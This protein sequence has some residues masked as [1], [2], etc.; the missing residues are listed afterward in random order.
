MSRQRI[1]VPG[2]WASKKIKRLY[3]EY[4]ADAVLFY[5]GLNSH[6]DDEGRGYNDLD[7]FELK[8]PF[9]A[10]K[11][12]NELVTNWLQT[13]DEL[14]LIKLYGEKKYYFVPDWFEKQ[15][16]PKPF[17]SEIL[18][19]PKEF[20][21]EFPNYFLELRAQ[22]S[23]ILQR[24][25]KEKRVTNQLRTSLKLVTNQLRTS[26]CMKLKEVKGKEVKG[27][28]VKKTVEGNI[29]FSLPE[30]INPKTWKDF[31][32]MRKEIKKPA[33]QKAQELLVKELTK[34]HEQGQD[35]NA[36]LE[37]SIINSW[38]GVFPLK[39]QESQQAQKK[40]FTLPSQK[41][42]QEGQGHE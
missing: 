13:S 1:F 7:W 6:A 27:K 39:T 40:K 5:W 22:L 9:M 10:A 14:S 31:L 26:S 16:I 11:F 24:F 15:K 32:D 30:F 42:K 17:P 29:D 8:M 20:T 36:I 25:I 18:L 28:E 35:P 21:K 12:S 38:R 33:T 37:E 34:F 2:F 4:G 19:P 23:K 41:A 3:R